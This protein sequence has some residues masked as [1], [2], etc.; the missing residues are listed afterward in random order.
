MNVEEIIS[1]E[2][3]T[4]SIFSK[5]F[6]EVLTPF[7]KW[8][9]IFFIITLALNFL[10]GKIVRKRRYKE[11]RQNKENYEK[12]H[13]SKKKE[14]NDIDYNLSYRSRPLFSPN[15]KNAYHKIKSMTDEKGLI[16]FAKVRLFDLLEPEPD[17]PNYK[18][19]KWKIQAKHVDFVI[20]NQQLDVMGIIELDDSS[21]NRKDRK[22]RDQFVDAILKNNGYKILHVRY[23]ELDS[24]QSK[25]T[26]V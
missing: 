26:T 7:I 16:L 17:T 9:I 14:K 12:K 22:E 15:E 18:G 24:L 8:G 13:S 4:N 11:Y 6:F 21:H 19:A 25:L 10:S 5:D 1:A 20:C 23:S 2:E 3:I